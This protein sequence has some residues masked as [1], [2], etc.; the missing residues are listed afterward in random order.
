MHG[1]Q[2]AGF[3]F[4]GDPGGH[5]VESERPDAGGL[6]G[7]F[8]GQE[9]LQAGAFEGV[10]AEVLGG[11]EAGASAEGR[12]E[13]LGRGHAGIGALVGDRLVG[14]QAMSA[15]GGL[16]PDASQMLDSHFHIY[17][18]RCNC[19]SGGDM[20]SLT[21]AGWVIYSDDSLWP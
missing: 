18:T 16:K 3:V 9:D 15:G 13:E 21:F 19:G 6:F 1:A 8:G 10:V 11:V 12:H 7:L 2:D 5:H 20:R 4:R 17:L 14:N